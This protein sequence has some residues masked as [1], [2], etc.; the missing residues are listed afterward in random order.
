MMLPYKRLLRPLFFRVPAEPAHKIAESILKRKI[1]WQILSSCFKVDDSILN[2]SLSEIPVSNPI[3]LAAGFDKNCQYLPSMMYLGFGYLVGGTV[4]LD[5]RDGNPKPRLLRDPKNNSIINSLGFPGQGIQK[6]ISNL[7]KERVSPLILS[8]SG[9]TVDDL[10]SCALKLEPWSDGIEI[11]IS[12]PNSKGLKIFHDPKIY[13]EMLGRINSSR[14]KP[15]FVKLPPYN[16]NKGQDEILQL[17][18][19]GA[20]SGI[21]GFTIAN[22][23][24]ITDSRLKMGN[25]GLSGKLIFNDMLQIIKDVRKEVRA[26]IAINACGGISTAE[27]A[28]LALKQGANTIQIYSALIYEGPGVVKSIKLGLKNYLDKNNLDSITKLSSTP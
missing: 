19:I 2:T 20:S 1:I 15:L 23:K 26:D 12:S 10:V 24:P 4:T 27:D 13:G 25:G 8:A 9:F 17:V 22:T 5:P 16:N 7:A 28:I 6:V 21:Q 11:N 18:N 14:K 3:G